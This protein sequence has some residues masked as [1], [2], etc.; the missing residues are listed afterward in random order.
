MAHWIRTFRLRPR[1][2]S[3]ARVL[4]RPTLAGVALVFTVAIA[5]E[6]GAPAGGPP[7]SAGAQLGGFTHAWR[8]SDLAAAQ[9]GRLKS[10][11]VEVG[12]TVESGALLARLEEDVQ[13]TRVDMAQRL[14]DSTLDVELS[15]KR[16]AHAVYEQERLEKLSATGVGSPDELADARLETVISDLQWRIAQRDHELAVQDLALQRFLLEQHLIRAPFPGYIAA[17]LKEAG[18]SVDL[19]E[20]VLTLVQLDPLKVVIDCPLVQL[21]ALQGCGQVLVRP[22]EPALAPRAA[23]VS[24]VSRTVD[25]GSQTVRVELVLPNPDGAWRAG[26]YVGI[27]IPSAPQARGADSAE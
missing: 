20:P 12:A 5:L 13:R 27:E 14:A 3:A 18:E 23:R 9:A 6:A 25:P 17:R 24:L 11:E 10:V 26:M 21:P 16:A 4:P 7:V 19:D 22:A 8:S 1:R 2:S 15:Q